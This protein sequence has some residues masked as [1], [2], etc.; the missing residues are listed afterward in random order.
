MSDRV[1]EFEGLDRCD[2]GKSAGTS[3]YDSD[4]GLLFSGEKAALRST[5]LGGK[6]GSD[7]SN[8]MVLVGACCP[9]L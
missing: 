7:L 1:R 3:E 2:G 9:C 8:S 6:D 5:A 4:I